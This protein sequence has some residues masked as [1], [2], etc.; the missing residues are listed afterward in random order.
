MEHKSYCRSPVSSR[1]LTEVHRAVQHTRADS[2]RMHPP[3]APSSPHRCPCTALRL[4]L[5]STFESASA[6]PPPVCAPFP[7]P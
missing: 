1:F 3:T 5:P 7:G 4:S 2:S 6:R